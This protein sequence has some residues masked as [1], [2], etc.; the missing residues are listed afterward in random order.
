MH[1]FNKEASIF[2]TSLQHKKNEVRCVSANS[3]VC[4]LMCSSPRAIY[5][6]PRPACQASPRAPPPPNTP[7]DNGS[8]S[9][10]PEILCEQFSYSLARRFRLRPPPPFTVGSATRRLRVRPPPPFTVDAQCHGRISVCVGGSAAPA[11]LASPAHHRLRATPLSELRVRRRLRP[12]LT[13]RYA[14]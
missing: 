6:L 11:P 8:N 7:P 10:P 14:C 1:L 12:P 4:R 9:G 3:C 5:P 13:R 2:I